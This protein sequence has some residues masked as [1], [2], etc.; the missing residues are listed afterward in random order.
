MPALLIFVSTHRTLRSLL[1]SALCAMLPMLAQGQG[2]PAIKAVIEKTLQ[3]QTVNV[4][5]QASFEIGEFVLNPRYQT[6]TDWA[7]TL[8]AGT[9]A[10]GKISV[11]VRC[12]QGV[13]GNFYVPVRVRIDGRYVVATHALSP[14]QTIGEAD[15]RI[16]EGE[17]TT[18]A[19][20][21]VLDPQQ[22]VG[23]VT[24]G[25]I[26]TEHP[27]RLSQL[28]LETL[29]QAGQDVKVMVEGQGFSVG[30][31]GTAIDSGAKGDTIRV[32]LQ[33]GQI[34]S[35]VVRDKGLIET[36]L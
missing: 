27:V 14:G 18:Q 12:T 19:P 2:I 3:G 16:V 4:P 11:N 32:R 17:L 26:I 8:P 6:C 20:D 35:G 33:N 13:T 23:R 36:R 7:A 30:N 29:V 9:R 10:W 21:L 5:G 15:L 25:F 24:R 31:M 22:A 28:R 34:I 1:I